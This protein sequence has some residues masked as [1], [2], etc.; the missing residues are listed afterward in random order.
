MF[1]IYYVV[2]QAHCFYDVKQAKNVNKK[3]WRI[4]DGTELVES[5]YFETPQQ[6]QFICDNMNKNLAKSHIEINSEMDKQA[7]LKELDK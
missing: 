3:I 1:V 7:K 2:D 4:T 6:A 5:M